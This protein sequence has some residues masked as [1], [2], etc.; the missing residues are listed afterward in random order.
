MMKQ[1]VVLP[2]IWDGASNWAVRASTGSVISGATA[3]AK[4]ASNDVL[5][6]MSNIAVGTSIDN[7]AP[8]AM[9]DYAINSAGNG[10]EVS[11][12]APEDHGV[13]SSFVFRGATQ[14][15]Y[16][17]E[18]YEVYRTVAGSEGFEL[19]GTAT[20]GSTSFIDDVPMGSNVYSYYVKAVDGNPDHMV[21]SPTRS[22]ISTSALKGDFTGDATINASDFSIFA[23]NYGKVMA[24]NEATFVGAYDL[25]SDGKIDA[26]DFSI[27][28]AAYGSTLSSAKA[29][30]AEMPTSDIPFG[31]SASIDDATST[32]FVNVNI[33]KA[34]GLKGFEFFMSYNTEAF[35]FLP[36]SVNGLVG[37]NMATQVEDGVIRISDWF[38]GQDFSGTVS[39]GFR[40]T[41]LNRTSTFEILNAVVDVDGLAHATN[42][43]EFEA[44]ALP[45][46]YA[47]SQNYPNPFNPTTTIDYSIPKSGNVEMVIYNASGQKVRSLVT[48]AQDAGFYKVVWDGRN[49]MGESVASGVYLYKLVSGSFS[50]TA[51][52]NLIK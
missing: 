52:M 36:N 20:P 3:A 51:K 30:V 19:I 48:G 22:G 29:A 46:V 45:T 34:D 32:Y 28:A 11:W 12:V 6:D 31:I 35:E 15:I 21:M 5:S 1:S 24:G 8:S 7:I 44:R 4:A 37:L 27:F 26:S 14:Y 33:D 42:V 39:L 10:I 23:A 9:T 38:I 18:K 17:V 47:L 40:S 41:G 16:G 2:T 25:N 13:V 43:S 49:D 50:K